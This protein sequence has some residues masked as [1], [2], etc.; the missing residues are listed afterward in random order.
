MENARLQQSLEQSQRGES[1]LLAV[2]A[3]LAGALWPAFGRIR[4]LSSQRKVLSEYVRTLESLRDQTNTLSEMLS[5]EMEG[6]KRA[7]EEPLSQSSRRLLRDGRNPVLVFRVGVIA[8]IAINRLC[9]LGSCSLKLFVSSESP[10]EFGGMS[11]VCCGRR[12]KAMNFKGLVSNHRQD[13]LSGDTSRPSVRVTS[14]QAWFTSLQLQSNFTGAVVEL[15]SA[16]RKMS[17]AWNGE[18]ERSDRD[19]SSRVASPSPGNNLIAAARSAYGKI[20]SGLQAEFSSRELGQEAWHERYSGFRGE[21]IGLLGL[22]LQKWLAKGPGVGL[23]Y[24]SSQVGQ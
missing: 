14:A 4:A 2:C 15:Q 12:T 18:S 22:G 16:L 5:N 20:I 3:L 24:I 9:N 17:E 13:S 7:K 21:L 1:S 6:E 11:V 10:G 23:T 19:G 8:V